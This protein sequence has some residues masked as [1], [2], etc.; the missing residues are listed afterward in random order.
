REYQDLFEAA[1]AALSH[2]MPAAAEIE[3][4]KEG[5]RRIVRDAEKRKGIVDRPRAD[6]IGK[7]GK[8]SQSVRRT[9]QE[10]DQGK[11]QWR[12]DDRGICGSTHRV[13]FHHI[14]DRGKG[15][16]GTP[17]NV[18]QLCQRHNLLAAE[19]AWGEQYMAK[20]RRQHSAPE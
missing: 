8:I 3:V 12:S 5:F 17:D 6:K 9:V 19:I 18:I 15:G 20:F 1:R 7:D 16:L 13:Q 10:R 4:I 11:C 14:Q 2:K